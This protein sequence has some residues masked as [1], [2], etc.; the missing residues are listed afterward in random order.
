[1]SKVNET[2]P[3]EA[4]PGERGMP[5]IGEPLGGNIAARKRIAGVMA[6]VALLV[7]GAVYLWMGG[8]KEEPSEKKETQ[9]FA[10]PAPARTFGD[11]PSKP[12]L[13]E[14]ALLMPMVPLAAPAPA[15][16]PPS[17]LLIE[18]A[19]K[20]QPR[21]SG[22][23]SGR[24]APTLDKGQSPLMV[25]GGSSATAVSSA[26]QA[27]SL[28]ATLASL[29]GLSTASAVSSAEAPTSRTQAAQVQASFLGD[30]NFLLAQGS[31]IDCV[32]QTRID[33][34]VP[35]MTSCVVSRNI[36]SDNGKVLLIE[37]GSTI[38]GEYQEGIKQGQARLFVLWNRIK[39][40]N[41]VIVNLEFPATDPLGGAGI[42]GKVKSKFFARVGAALLLSLVDD[43][44]NIAAAALN[45]G[46]DQVISFGNTAGAAQ[47]A[48]QE[49]VKNTINIKP[50]L[51]KN[52]GEVIGIYVARDI[53]FSGVYRATSK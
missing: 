39:T 19:P 46:D 11:P 36:F 28:E 38:S 33:S 42:P 5:A 40:P 24:R 3:M 30:R 44:G 1:M 8:K 34:T 52:Q 35:G 23:G 2:Q 29:Q 45:K 32:L 10:A 51:S 49:I 9:A 22:G 37:R 14:S 12:R 13:D 16:Q 27:P 50:V 48:A 17:P 6:F 15:V 20:P 41:G 4:L 7:L 43:A 47:G 21:A 31:F 25:G 53:D 26:P 18:E